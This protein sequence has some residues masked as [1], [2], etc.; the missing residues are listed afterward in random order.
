LELRATHRAP[1]HPVARRSACLTG[2]ALAAILL[3][4]PLGLTASAHADT[5]SQ[6]PLQYLKADQAWNIAKGSGAT[7]AV[8][9]TGT[10]SI[11]DTRDALESGADFSSGATSTGNGQN[12]IDG[13]G[14]EMAALI[15]GAGSVIT[16]L[17]PA[18]KIVP[19][20]ATIGSGMQ[21]AELASAV[22]YAISQHVTVINIS[23]RVIGQDAALARAVQE[24]VTDNIVVVAA[25]GDEAQSSVDYPAAYPGV[26]AVGAIGQSGAIWSSSNTGSHVTLAA[27]GVDVPSEDNFGSSGTTTGTSASTAYVSATAAL[28]RSAHPSWTAGQ[29]IRD[30]IA[31]ADPGNGQV[32]GQHSDQYGYGIVDP[33]R[34]LLASAPA[35]TTNPLI[36]SADGSATTAAMGTAASAGSGATVGARVHA[37]SSRSHTGPI[38]GLG[39]AIVVVILIIVLIVVLSRRNRN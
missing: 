15:V 32:T 9:D 5:S 20:S 22:R 37:A 29:V 12:D 26:V 33:L 38:A 13:H 24:A 17:A 28:I 21:P 6:W 16:G 19:V 4:T 3:S 25:A 14:T 8:L 10:A 35:E 27:P 1:S 30:L 36:A 34:A 23:L 7:I 11:S 31:S 2:A 39:V 18:A